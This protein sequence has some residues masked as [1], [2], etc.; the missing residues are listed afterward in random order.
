MILI[1][2]FAAVLA[3]AEALW[4][5]LVLIVAGT[6]SMRIA[7]VFG[8]VAYIAS[9][10]VFIVLGAFILGWSLGD[11]YPTYMKV[12]AGTMSA[13]IGGVALFAPLY[14]VARLRKPLLNIA[15]IAVCPLA[16]LFVLFVVMFLTSFRGV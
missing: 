14:F 8:P 4:A 2:M 10:A 11:T 5:W 12:R 15:A 9:V 6:V 3:N 13:L 7:Q 1:D 16:S